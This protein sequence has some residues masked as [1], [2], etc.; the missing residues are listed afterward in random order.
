[1]IQHSVKHAGTAA[2]TSQDNRVLSAS[3]HRRMAAY[4]TVM[5]GD[6]AAKTPFISPTNENPNSQT[7]ENTGIRQDSILM[8]RVVRLAL[9]HAISRRHRSDKAA[10]KPVDQRQNSN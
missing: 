7:N 8:L 2:R 5:R 10:N 4:A 6:G 1:M 3:P 9:R